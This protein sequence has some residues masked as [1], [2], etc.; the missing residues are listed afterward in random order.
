M[1]RALNFCITFLNKVVYN[2]FLEK[3]IPGG[4]ISTPGVVEACCTAV[5]DTGTGAI[6]KN[7]DIIY[8]LK[9]FNIVAEHLYA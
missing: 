6:R 9:Y 4:G 8:I 5:E 1:E 3:V 2:S 7:N